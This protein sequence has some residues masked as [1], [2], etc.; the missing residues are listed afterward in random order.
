MH[1][2]NSVVPCSSSLPDQLVGFSQQRVERFP[3]PL[4]LGGHGGHSKC[5]HTLQAAEDCTKIQR[6]KGH[7][8]KIFK[9]A[10]LTVRQASLKYGSAKLQPTLD[11]FSYLI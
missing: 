8:L 4:P 11:L 5:S 9:E 1:L 3:R 6:V 2:D 10:S 7:V